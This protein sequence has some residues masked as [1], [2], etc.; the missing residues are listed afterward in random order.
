MKAIG[1]MAAALLVAGKAGAAPLVGP[2]PV[3]DP[4][5]VLVLGTPHLSAIGH[6]RPEWL[7][8]LLDRLAAW[9]PQVIAMEGLSGPECYLLRRYEKTWPD[10]AD[11][12]CARSERI[13]GL[14]AKTT[15][16]DMPA[17]EAAVEE[18]IAKL[19]PAPTPAARRRLAAL[20]SAAGNVGSATVLDRC[21]RPSRSSRGRSA[22]RCRAPAPHGG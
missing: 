15:G 17:A 19:G 1:F 8:P 22:P 5:P 20:F 21:S 7:T 10:T 13:S 12:Y 9:K 4:T 14:A 16:L 6:L 18:A 3:A 11:S 2:W